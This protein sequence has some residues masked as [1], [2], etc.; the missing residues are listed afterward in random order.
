M[1]LK[2]SLENKISQ[3][4]RSLKP[5]GIREFFDIVSNNPDCISFGVGEPDFIS[6]TIV[7]E[8]SIS[9]LREGYTH[10]TNN[11]GFLSLRNE[12]SSYL[13]KKY[14][15]KYDAISEI[16][17]TVGVSQGLDLGI[18]SIV[19][20]GD[21]VIYFSPSY[22]SYEPL[23]QM[24]GGIPVKIS[25]LSQQ[26]FEVD[27]N[28]LESCISSKTKAILL[29]YPSNPTGLSFSEKTLKKIADIS[30]QKGI[31]VISDEIYA[32]IVYDKKHIPFSSLSQ[33]Q[34]QTILLGGFS[35]SFAM[36][37]FRIGYVCGPKYW[38]EA[39]LKVHQYTMLCAPT[40][41]QI[42]AEAALV[43]AIDEQKKMNTAYK[44]RKNYIVK[45]LN[46]I[47]ISCY[48]PDG[49]FYVFASIKKYHEDSLEFAKNLF[50]KEKVAIVP[51]TAFGKEW[52]S[53]IRISYAT[54]LEEIKLG[55]KK[56][57]KFLNE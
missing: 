42:A 27:F 24:A 54:N 34:N 33:M 4:I 7:I 50:Y 48:M 15:L 35:K 55:I 51:G 52:N 36:T 41:A 31:L 21:E 29:N 2:F 12:I 40:L 30:Y 5:S 39:I 53:F 22:V 20:K 57:K 18:R 43:D 44:I 6:P 11:Q 46:D 9:A 37:G 17:I 16:V 8:K 38:I 25:L 1:A 13:Q 28:K 56:I 3:V 45:E 49:A 14:N 26:N 19:E 10:Y 32:D 23:I 47:G